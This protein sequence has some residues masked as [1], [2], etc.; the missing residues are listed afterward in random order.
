MRRRRTSAA[1]IGLGTALSALL[2]LSLSTATGGETADQ[3]AS[4]P[5]AALARIGARNERA[6]AEAA[7]ETR[8]N[9]QQNLLISDAEFAARNR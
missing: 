5:P 9:A 1:L 8:A 4:A 6:S 3:Q 2:V 7:A